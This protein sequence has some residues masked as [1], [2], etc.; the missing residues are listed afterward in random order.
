VEGLLVCNSSTPPHLYGAEKPKTGRKTAG[1]WAKPRRNPGR[2]SG[3][4][5]LLTRDFVTAI[6][7]G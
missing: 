3:K 5:A 7:E 2:P 1:F 6:D 4:I